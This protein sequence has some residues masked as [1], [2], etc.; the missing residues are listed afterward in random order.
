MVNQIEHLKQKIGSQDVQMTIIGLGYVGLPLAL[1]YAQAGFSVTGL[2]KST[3]K[4]EAL[5][6]GSSDVDDISDQ[7]LLEVIQSNRLVITSE[8]NVLANADVIIICVPTP[9]SKT[10]APDLSFILDAIDGISI[11]L[12]PGQVVVLESTTYPGT[13]D[14]LVQPKLESTGLVS[15]KDISLAYSPERIDPGNKKFS[16]RE[17]PKIVA[18]ITPACRDTAVMLYQQIVDVVVPVSTTRTAEM[19]KILENT[20]RSV[21]IGLVNE[22]ALI[23]DKL[24]IDVWETID[25][26]ASKPFGYIPFYPGPGLGGHCIPV[27]PH[28]LSWKLMSLDYPARFIALAS[29]VNGNMPFYVVS[30]IA[31]TL[32]EL[33]LSVKKS[34]ILILGVAYKADI[35]DYRE[36]PALDVMESLIVKG[37]TVSYNDP[38]ISQI[39]IRDQHFESVYLSESTIHQSDC[40]VIL[41][42]HSV[43]DIPD[44][45]RHAR[46]VV[47]TRNATKTIT[48]NH[49]K[50]TRI[51]V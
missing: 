14:E 49:E 27:D 18:G 13:T 16:L 35:G 11:Y 47:D 9:L 3:L 26:A 38:Y 45:V 19:V 12:H 1:A 2:D 22:I 28:Y 48:Q 10:K 4:T 50:I 25:A 41:T 20:F 15:G 8:Y 24:N 42:N 17:I 23:C 40:V 32:N 46:A 31:D 29:E 44:I 39:T 6:K 7:E 34:K 37:A 43:Y 5:Q 30:K 36:S 51:G 33:E 21:N